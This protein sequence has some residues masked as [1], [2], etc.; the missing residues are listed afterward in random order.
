MPGSK[1]RVAEYLSRIG[2]P[3]EVKAFGGSTRNSVLAAQELGCGVE[4]IAKSVV[5]VGNGT[6]VVVLS[7]DR[8]VDTSKL[9]K[10]AG[11]PL[12]VATPDEV[13]RR[14]GYPV[15]GIPP[16]PHQEGVAVIP[17]A[18]L[19]RFPDVWAAAGAPNAVFRVRTEDILRTLGREPADLSVP[20][21][22]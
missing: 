13:R 8:R 1:E 4:R 21:E 10:V 3:V 19:T 12:R 16:F 7:G 17:D 5:F 2:I 15:G 22:I 20:Q 14:T 6:F 11:G 18:S 9:E